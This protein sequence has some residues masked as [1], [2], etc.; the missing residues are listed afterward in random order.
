MIQEFKVKNFL[1]FK[2]E[3]TFSF[4]ATSDL[5]SEEYQVVTMANGV[6]LLRLAI[7]YGFNASGKTNLL[8]A[9]DFVTRFCSSDYSVAG[10]STGAQP[11]KLNDVSIKAPSRFEILFFVENGTKY[12]YVLEL[13]AEQVY[14]ER[15][16]CYKSIQPTMLFERTLEKGYSVI[17]FNSNGDRISAASKEQITVNCLKNISFFEAKAKVNVSLPLIDA[18]RDW[19]VNHTMPIILPNTQLTRFAQ[20]RTMSDLRLTEDLIG[21]LH[22]ADFNITSIK[23][24]K[25]SANPNDERGNRSFYPSLDTWFEHTVVSEGKEMV[26]YLNAD[27]QSI[28]TMR[29]FGLESAILSAQQKEAFL[30]IDELE[31]SLHPKLQEKML[32]NYLQ[33]HSKSQIIVSTHNDGLL[34]LT[35]DLI[36]KDSVWFTDKDESASTDLY[37]LTDFRGLNRLSSIREAYRN[38]RFGATMD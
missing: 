7:V 24:E 33:V 5:F 34:D 23:T 37:R 6:R 17:H 15:L 38:K 1:S 21:F 28:G 9:F 25:R 16:T 26:Y 12:S 8:R 10:R 14:Y 11:F 20:R 3:V 35:D 29:T 4:E 32:F 18:A 30:P 36:R 22:D 19:F 31:T 13:D 2:D 27:D